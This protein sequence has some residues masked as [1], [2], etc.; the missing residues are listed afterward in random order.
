MKAALA[1]DQADLVRL[2]L[3]Q[4][5]IV[6]AAGGQVCEEVF[7]AQNR[8]NLV[9]HYVVKLDDGSYL[10]D[11]MAIRYLGVACRHIYAV[12]NARRDLPWHIRLINKR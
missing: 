8:A 2:N 11:C 7:E 9:S 5:L 3:S 6:I 1:E 10:C 4:L 12:L